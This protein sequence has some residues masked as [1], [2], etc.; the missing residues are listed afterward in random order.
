MLYRFKGPIAVVANGADIAHF[1]P[2]PAASKDVDVLFAGRIERRKGSRPM[3]DLC[4]LLVAA[5]PSIRIEIIGYGDDDEYVRSELE[6]LQPAVHLAGKTPFAK[7]N[8]E[9]NRSRVYASTSY[10]EGLPGT[11]LEAM[12]AGLPTVV[13]DFP[14]YQGLVDNGRTGYVVAPN[15]LEGMK[16]RILSLLDD[17]AARESFGKASREWLVSRYDW[18]VL[19]KQI[20]QELSSLS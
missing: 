16:D 7:M 15:N 20:V 5:R 19:A 4:K 8:G 11:C 10:Y 2:E 6:P 3:V 17:A 12:A 1:H 9:Y 18:R 14:F 13:W